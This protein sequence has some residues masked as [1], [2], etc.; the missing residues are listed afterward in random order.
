MKEKAFYWNEQ[1]VW[2]FI[3]M[4]FFRYNENPLGVSVDSNTTTFG[5]HLLKRGDAI[6]LFLSFSWESP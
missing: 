1:N 5:F 6:V 4:T 2:F 3:P